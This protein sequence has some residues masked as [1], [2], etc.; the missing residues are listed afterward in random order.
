MSLERFENCRN[1]N[2][3]VILFCDLPLAGKRYNIVGKVLQNL[4]HETSSV[5]RL[6]GT[7]LV[8]DTGHKLASPLWVEEVQWPRYT[9]DDFA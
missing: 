5:I 1:K 3:V 4:D 7:L 9:V 6:P 8:A 2:P